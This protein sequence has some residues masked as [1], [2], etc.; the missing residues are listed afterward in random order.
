MELRD[1]LVQAVGI[2][3]VRLP[4]RRVLLVAPE[5]TVALHMLVVLLLT[6]RHR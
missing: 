3:Q 6:M 4:V 2:Q 5:E 1:R